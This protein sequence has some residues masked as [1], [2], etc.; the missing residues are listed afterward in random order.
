MIYHSTHMCIDLRIFNNIIRSTVLLILFGGSALAS[1]KTYG[2]AK[3]SVVSIYDG[4]TIFVDVHGWPDIIGKRIPVRISGIDTPERGDKN[5]NIR[6]MAS[7]ARMFVVSKVRG[8]QLLEIKNMRR[9][10]YF[11]IVADIIIDGENIGETL[12]KKGLAKKYD[13]GTKSKWTDLDYNEYVK[14]SNNR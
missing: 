5:A 8:K 12:I 6:E 4:D 7:Q 2:D 9:D 3:C 11:R 10:K 13:G 1:E 14:R